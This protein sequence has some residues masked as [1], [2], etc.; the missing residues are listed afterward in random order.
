MLVRHNTSDIGGGGGVNDIAIAV[1]EDTQPTK[2]SQESGMQPTK[3]SHKLGGGTM[4][5]SELQEGMIVELNGIGDLYFSRDAK[6]LKGVPL[7][8]VKRN[9]D[10][11]V[12]L[13]TPSASFHSYALRH[14]EKKDE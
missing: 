13:Q 2:N 8:V 9:K 3:N 5:L 6:K 14:L 1:D 4:K 10:G 7:T 12:L 11:T